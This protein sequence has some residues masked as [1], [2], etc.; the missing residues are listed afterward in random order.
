[1]RTTLRFQLAV[2]GG[3]PVRDNLLPYGR[4]LVDDD[5]IAAVV[6]VLRGGWLTT[7]PMVAEFERDFAAAVGAGHAVAV[8]SGTAALHA[9]ASAASL[10]PE[11]EVLVPAM[12]FAATA[13]AVRY[14]GGIP[15]FVDVCPDTLNIDPQALAAAVTPRTRA[16]FAVD[17]AGIPSNYDALQAVA[18][19]HNLVLV[20]D[21]AHA[22]GARHRGRAVGTL[23]RMTAFSLH[24]VKHITTGEG[25]VVTTDSAALAT[26][27]R[28][29]RNHGITTD[30]HQRSA[31]GSWLY[32]MRDLGFNYRLTDFQCALGQSQLKKLPMWLARR[33]EIAAVYTR[34][35]ERI[36]EIELPSV[37]DWAEPAWHLYVV[38][39]NLDRLRVGRKDVFAALRA[40]GI[41][42]NVHYIPVPWHPYYQALGYRKGQW[43]VAEKEY[44]RLLSLPMW[45]GMTDADIQDTILAVEKVIAAYR[46]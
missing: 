32:E 14:T 25:G 17:F 39:L 4:Q 29:F 24:P 8:S 33:R 3:R 34:A 26:Q 35:F 18:V 10:G 40:E 42:V 12:T 19:R 2:D 27:L 30:H 6:H 20:A 37:P 9:A 21:A 5:D 45:A 15:V 43:P 16:I 22:L 38:R 11:C 41:G 31:A 36:P 28:A 1:M 7:G 13:N 46:R 23:A 44:E